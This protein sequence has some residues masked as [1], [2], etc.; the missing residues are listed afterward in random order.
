MRKSFLLLILS[1]QT[2]MNK[3]IIL[4]TIFILLGFHIAFSQNAFY[5]FY[6]DTPSGASLEK[7]IATHDNG[8]ISLEDAHSIVLNKFDSSGL[9]IWSK[10]Y[11]VPGV[12]LY[13]GDIAELK[14]HD[15]IIT[16]EYSDTNFTINTYLIMRLDSSGNLRYAKIDHDS[17]EV[18]GYR[19]GGV[20]IATTTPDDGVIM[21]GQIEVDTIPGS[22]LF[23]SKADSSGNPQWFNIFQPDTNTDFEEIRSAYVG[24]GEMVITGFYS[25]RNIS[26][27]S[28][29]FFILKFDS[30]GNPVWTKKIFSGSRN[31][32]VADEAIEKDGELYILTAQDT[33][34]G[35]FGTPHIYKIDING[36]LLWHTQYDF[37]GGISNYN[38]M[39]KRTDGKISFMARENIYYD[40]INVEIDS[41][42]S[43]INSQQYF[44]MPYFIYLLNNFQINSGKII[45]Y[46][47]GSDLISFGLFFLTLDSVYQ[48]PCFST[49][50]SLP[51]PNYFSD[52]LISMTC[53]F[54]TAANSY[55]DIT[56]NIQTSS[57]SLSEIDFCNLVHTPEVESQKQFSISPNPSCGQF[58]I[59]SQ[60][61]TDKNSLLEI[62]NVF[63]ACIYTETMHCE[64]CIVHCALPPG[65]YFV[66]LSNS[67]MQSTQKLVIE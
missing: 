39:Y 58:V 30:S 46:G 6:P 66:R 28:S 27:S 64:S 59:S 56:S 49:P 62:F 8:F 48:A 5:H 42:G 25:Y 50:I 19:W 57:F 55:T 53:P 34:S 51:Q 45:S 13:A 38:N 24:N 47:F 40:Y 15:L 35:P 3:I 44:S 11:S 33:P 1:N 22:A 63:G 31:V 14:N 26:G 4:S 29:W 32:A 61:F 52:T 10:K 2:E 37:L 16:G 20:N 18:A 9:S 41:S 21:L 60:S 36:Q 65:I 54:Y 17:I 7:V 12:N 43:I 67:E 23:I